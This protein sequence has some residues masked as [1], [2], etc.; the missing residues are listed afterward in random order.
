LGIVQ[1]LLDFFCPVLVGLLTQ[2]MIIVEELFNGLCPQRK[3]CTK[4]KGHQSN[5]Q[6]NRKPHSD[7][8]VENRSSHKSPGQGYRSQGLFD[9][10]QF[11]SASKC[12]LCHPVRLVPNYVSKILQLNENIEYSLRLEHL[13]RIWNNGI[14]EGW[15]VGF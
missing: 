10:G 1:L 12:I 9:P 11:E 3:V 5:G 6:Q 2:R 4:R 14:V 13:P 8:R 15:K 7:Q